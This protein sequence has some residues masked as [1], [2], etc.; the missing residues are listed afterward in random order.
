MDLRK[1]IEVWRKSE[2]QQYR[3]VDSLRVEIALLKSQA[4]FGNFD[5]AEKQLSIVRAKEYSTST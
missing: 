3:L 2:S 5:R 1:G 4:V